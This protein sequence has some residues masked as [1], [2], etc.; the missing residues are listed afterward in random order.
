MINPTPPIGAGGY[1]GVPAATPPTV[2]SAGQSMAGAPAAGLSSANGVA[3]SNPSAR[4]DSLSESL[5]NLLGVLAGDL[6]DDPMLRMI[7]ALLILL[8]LI[9]RTQLGESGGG[10]GFGNQLGSGAG[11][12]GASGIGI[13]FFSTSIEMTASISVT[14]TAVYA[15][16]LGQGAGDRIDL[17]A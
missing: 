14:Q 13:A 17:S 4:P 2:G 7:V 15:G 1:G 9:E 16:D 8:A 6:Q 5:S 12:L 11:G 3:G 10:W